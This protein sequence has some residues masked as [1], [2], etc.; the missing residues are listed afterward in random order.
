MA[1][2]LVVVKK[3]ENI[4]TL[5]INRPQKRNSMNPETLLQ[6]GDALNALKEDGQ[7]RLVVIRGAGEEAFSSGYDIGRI[8]GASDQEL[9]GPRRN[10]LAY[11]MNSVSGFPYP[12]IAMIFGY[13]VGAGLELAA[14]CDLRFAAEGARLGITPAKLGVVYSPQGLQKF[15]NLVGVSQTKELF[16]TG[17]LI[18]AQRA[19]EIGLVDHVRP[20]GEL[21]KF[22]YDLAGEIAGNA[23]LSVSGTKTTIARLLKYQKLNPEDEDEL[24]KLQAQAMSSEDL[25]E[26]QKAFLEKRKPRFTGR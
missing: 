14:T 23:P 8:G 16:Y 24:R 15:L 1:E 10:P 4:C 18:D 12:V 9:T 6:L 17:R 11:G 3:E 13:A 5:I 22:T 26:G 7:T 20:A 25:K 21:V 19:L 2:E